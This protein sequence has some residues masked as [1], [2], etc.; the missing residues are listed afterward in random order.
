MFAKT[1]RFLMSVAVTSLMLF[2][3]AGMRAQEAKQRLGSGLVEERGTVLRQFSG[4]AFPPETLVDPR[5]GDRVFYHASFPNDHDPFAIDTSQ[6]LGPRGFGLRV[7]D[8]G[9]AGVLPEGGSPWLLNMIPFGVAIDG[10][11]LDPSGPWYD[12]GPAD[13]DNPFDRACSGWEYEVNHPFVADLVG[14]PDDIRG[15]VQPGG[16]FHYHGY[17]APMI[18]AARIAKANNTGIILVGYSGDGFPIIDHRLT[19]HDGRNVVLVSGYVLRSGTRQPVPRTNPDLVPQGMYDGLYVQDFVYDPA[20][21]RAQVE[22]LRSENG[23]WFGTTIGEATVIRML[24]PRNGVILGSGL[25]QLTGHPEPHYAYVLTPDWPEIPRLFAFEPDDS[26]KAIIPFEVTGVGPRLAALF[27]A[28]VPEGR[29]AI[30]DNCG[31]QTNDM[32][33]LSAERSPY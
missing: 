33:G 9:L 13:P 24:D 5:T 16:M 28:D 31:I 1:T 19:T 20:K 26:F 4:P 25:Q 32:R 30:Y 8:R 21:K 11:I 29:K 2:P 3:P 6:R 7:K 27:G 10:S 15:H 18:A 12:G 23:N 22:K 17:P 14:V